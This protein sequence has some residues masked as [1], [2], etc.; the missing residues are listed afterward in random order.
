MGKSFSKAFFKKFDTDPR[1]LCLITGTIRREKRF[2]GPYPF[3]LSSFN[4]PCMI[5]KTLPCVDPALGLDH[6]APEGPGQT[7]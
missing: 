3:L 6:T 2:L 1:K 7:P 4:L 5:L